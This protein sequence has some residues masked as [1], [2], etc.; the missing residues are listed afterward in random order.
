[1]EEVF[2]NLFSGY[3]RKR[4][5][6]DTE[7]IFKGSEEELKQYTSN[8]FNTPITS[9]EDFYSKSIS[10]VFG[11]FKKEISYMLQHENID[12]GSTKETRQ[13][14]NWISKQ[15]KEGNITENC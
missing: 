7:S 8:I 14:T 15:I 3:I 2:C 4:I 6:K 11:K 10:S 12:F 9:F 5:N 1:M 13:I